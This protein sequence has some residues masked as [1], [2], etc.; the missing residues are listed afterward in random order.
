MLL[1]IYSGHAADAW[2]LLDQVWP[3][4]KLAAGLTAANET[5]QDFVQTGEINAI[6]M[7]KERFIQELISEVHFAVAVIAT[8]RLRC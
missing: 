3:A 6:D 5:R 7:T 2:R 8:E 4:G 1:M